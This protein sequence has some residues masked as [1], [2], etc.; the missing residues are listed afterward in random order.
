[1]ILDRER[2]RTETEKSPKKQSRIILLQAI[3]KFSMKCVAYGRFFFT[4]DHHDDDMA[5]TSSHNIFIIC[6]GY[7]K[8]RIP[9]IID[10]ACV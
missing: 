7:Q 1:M 2:R 4:L 8:K 10:I 3:N 6:R 5:P 9:F